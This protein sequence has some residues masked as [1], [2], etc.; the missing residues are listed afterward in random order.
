MDY[1]NNESLGKIDNS[2]LALA[3]RTEKMVNLLI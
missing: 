3:D 2:H 1:I